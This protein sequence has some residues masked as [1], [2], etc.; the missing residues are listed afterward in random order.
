MIRAIVVRAGSYAMVMAYSAPTEFALVYRGWSKSTLTVSIFKT[1]QTIAEWVA[2]SVV[3]RIKTATLEP[4]WQHVLRAQ[5]TAPMPALICRRTFC[6]ADNVA[7]HATSTKFA[8][9]DRVR[10]GVSGAGVKPVRALPAQGCTPRAANTLEH[11]A[12]LLVSRGPHARNELKGSP[13][14]SLQP[15]FS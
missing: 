8:S 9:V 11:Q 5:W 10:I 6:I 7:M 2:I 12:L 13:G 15:S 14:A 1:I 4:V 3:E